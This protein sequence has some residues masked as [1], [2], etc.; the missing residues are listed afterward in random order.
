MR[1]LRVLLLLLLAT[2]VI[3]LT[4]ALMS[5][6]TGFA[7]KAVLVGIIA[8]CVYLAAHAATYVERLHARLH[9]P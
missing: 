5:A 6:D 7:E 1:V 4:L 3:S 2:V 9:R 8:G